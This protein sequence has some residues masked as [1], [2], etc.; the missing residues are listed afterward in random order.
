M[1]VHDAKRCLLVSLIREER[2]SAGDPVLGSAGSDRHHG[3]S[4]VLQL[5]QPQLVE[6]GP[7]PAC[8][9]SDQEQ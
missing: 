6:V 2:D 5:L 9:K 1:E 7:R 3:Q 4:A 8:P